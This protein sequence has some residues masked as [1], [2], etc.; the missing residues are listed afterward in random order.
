MLEVFSTQ[1]G[2]YHPYRYACDM[3]T[4]MGIV[5]QCMTGQS[6]CH[7]TQAHPQYMMFLDA[8]L[9]MHVVALI[10]S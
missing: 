6:T 10:V 7:M 8:P 9:P 1:P 3:A 2:C 5:L 4:N